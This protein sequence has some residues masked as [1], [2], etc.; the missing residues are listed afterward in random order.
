M[1]GNF[2]QPQLDEQL[3]A[4]QDH[5]RF[6]RES[7]R[8][9]DRAGNLVPL[10]CWPSQRKLTA[11][12]NK[13][14]HAGK[15]VRIVTLKTRRSGFT[16]GSCSHIF[17]KVPFVGGRQ[18]FI[19]ADKY[20]PAA[21][22]AFGYL[23]HFN[24]H[25]QPFGWLDGARIGLPLN[26]APD[27]PESIKWSN[28]SMIEVFSADRGEI[29]GGGRHWALFDEVAFWRAPELT[30]RS[31]MVMVPD[32]AETG[33]IVQSTANGVG[34][35]FHEFCQRAMDPATAEGWQFIF[36]GWLEDANNRKPF[37]HAEDEVKLQRSLDRDET[38]LHEVHNA[39]LQQLNWRRWKIRT[40]FRGRVED[41]HQEYPTTAEEAFLTSGRPALTTKNLIHMPVWKDPL[42]G[43]LVE[44]EEF[45]SKKLRFVPRENGILTIG[46]RPDPAKNYILAAD[47][48]KGVDVS[49]S[50][51]GA[52]PD[53]AVLGVFDA[54][55]GE[56]VA[57]ARDRLRPVAFGQLVAQVGKL[58]NWAFL[59]PEAND[60][61]FIDSILGCN[62]PLERIYNRRRDPTDR[63]SIQPQE[64]GFET[65][66]TTRP[67]LISVLDDAI[68]ELAIIIRSPIAQQECRTF[69]IKPNGKAE[70]QTG[71]HDDC[72]VMCALA[73]IGFRFIPRKMRRLTTSGAPRGVS[74]YGAKPDDE[75]D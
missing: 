27:S 20:R 50:K 32:L 74:T 14:R 11:A 26:V 70:G 69:V 64:L 4:F 58:Y 54:D 38:A 35:E 16:V 53:F 6:C 63:R 55:T 17:A 15:P 57:Q 22:E 5:E 34:D 47:P 41:F 68:R 7:L 37:D 59:V 24:K 42:V 66:N 3:H 45:P 75:D 31:A 51:R 25:F 21:L 43:E 39:T 60:P 36:F 12:I 9:P 30:L 48:A 19:V 2:T 67:W 52:D 1:P 33:I 44:V 23:E 46:K 71:C 29:R 61:G 18:G 49:L 13:Q 28:D 8:L 10:G 73:G 65:T 72:V 62:Y 56:Q 40:T